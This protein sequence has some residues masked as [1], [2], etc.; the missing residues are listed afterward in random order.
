MENC[1]DDSSK[2][3]VLLTSDLDSMNPFLF[4]SAMI[5]EGVGLFEELMMALGN[6]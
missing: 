3:K 4:A 5:S 2:N 6:V 1:G